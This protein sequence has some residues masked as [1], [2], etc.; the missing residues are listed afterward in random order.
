MKKFPHYKQ[1]EAKDCGPTCIKI[2]AKHYGKI[3]NRQ[4]LRTLSET[5]KEGSS[6]LGLSEAVEKMGFAL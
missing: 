5:T 4:Q 1:N 6:L 3:I 2:I